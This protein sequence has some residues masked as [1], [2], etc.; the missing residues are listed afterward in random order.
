MFLKW[1]SDPWS[2]RGNDDTALLFDMEISNYLT[3]NNVALLLCFTLDPKKKI[4]EG[5]VLVGDKVLDFLIPSHFPALGE[6]IDIWNRCFTEITNKS[7][8]SVSV[9]PSIY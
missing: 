3:E 5:Q 6:S 1:P 2:F 7:E 8:S 9:F 4:L